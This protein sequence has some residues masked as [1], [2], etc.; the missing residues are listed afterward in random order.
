M[1]PVLKPN[2]S[3]QSITDIKIRGNIVFWL[4]NR[5][6]NNHGT[7]WEAGAVCVVLAT[8]AFGITINHETEMTAKTAKG[9]KSSS[10]NP[11]KQAF[12]TYHIWIH[13]WNVIN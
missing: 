11:L 10:I 8:V 2:V 9:N 7:I 1:L 6:T 12:H 4:N 3:I 5:V 13:F